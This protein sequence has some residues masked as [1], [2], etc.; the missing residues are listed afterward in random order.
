M[1]ELG[2]LNRI[3]REASAFL[4]P[5][6]SA[7]PEAI[8]AA[9][10]P[11]DSDYAA[12]FAGAAAAQARKGY[13]AFWKTPPRGLAK[14]GQTEVVAFALQADALT[15]D[16]EFSRE[17]PGGYRKIAARLNPDNV[18]VSFKFVVPGQTT[19]MA[20]DGLVLLAGRWAWF[21]K[22]WRVLGDTN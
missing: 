6:G 19:G 22:P 9:L 13:E 20:Y 14:P 7:T 2:E 16:N 5:L 18:W 11:R 12:V 17:F 10:A 4:L 21:P 15:T 1:I 8:A 3:K